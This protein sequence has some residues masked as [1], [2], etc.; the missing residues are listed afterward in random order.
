MDN[1]QE[2]RLTKAKI[3]IQQKSSFFAYLSLYLKLKE[4]NEVPSA[5]VDTKGNMGYNSKFIKGLSDENIQAVMIHEILHQALLHLT[6]L[7]TRDMK[8]YN[9]ATDLCI[10]T[11]IE[12]E[13]K[14]TLPKD[15]LIAD[16]NDEFKIPTDVKEYVIKNISEKN[17]DVIYDELVKIQNHYQK[18]TKKKGKGKNSL[19]D[20]KGFDE[21]KYENLSP[22]EKKKVENEI[23]GRVAT[24]VAMAKMK[25]DLPSGIAKMFDELHKE[26]IDWRTILQRIITKEIPFDYTFSKPHKKSYNY[27]VYMPNVLKESIDISIVVDLSGSVGQEEY[28][29][30]FSEIVGMAR[31][32]Q[33]RI[34][35]RFYSHDTKCY[36]CGLV[37]NGNI[38]EL[39]K[40]ELKGGGGTSHKDVF[41][42]LKKD[43]PKLA[44]FLTDG[45]SDLEDINFNEYGFKKI[46]VISKNGNSDCVKDK[47][48]V[49]AL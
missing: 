46:F 44:I 21:H 25:G 47:C 41:E 6:R 30:F 42:T 40:L 37:R 24:A 32:Y 28:A 33:N 15:C 22:E 48:E 26:K 14:Y 16:Y 19:E 13:G 45:F 18:N 8:L 17:A 9:V 29:D 10:N 12:K 39:K 1:E 43:K 4:D 7:G 35:M 20:Y 31:A 3:R 27:G 49:I 5:Y 36:D 2:E 34:T 38:E 23:S 11:I